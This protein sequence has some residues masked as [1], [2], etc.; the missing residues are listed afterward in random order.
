MGDIDNDD[1]TRALEFFSRIEDAIINNLEED[2]NNNKSSSSSNGELCA[3]PSLTATVTTEL[4]TANS[5]IS[6]SGINSNN[7][8]IETEEEWFQLGQK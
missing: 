3:R 2:V 4:T 1:D 6:S 7:N 5:S 8:Q